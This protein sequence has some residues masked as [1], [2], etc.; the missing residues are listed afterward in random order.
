VK[1]HIT[2][3]IEIVPKSFDSIKNTERSPIRV[4]LFYNDM[5]YS[6]STYD[7][8]PSINTVQQNLPPFL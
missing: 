7:H 5:T 4:S 8:R 1:C 6:L 3:E 2:A